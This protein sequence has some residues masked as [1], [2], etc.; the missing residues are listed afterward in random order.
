MKDN[1]SNELC[2]ATSADLLRTE[3]LLIYQSY[4]GS[5]PSSFFK[6]FEKLGK[7]RS[8][9]FPCNVEKHIQPLRVQ[10]G[11][12]TTLESCCAFTDLFN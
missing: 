1:S 10:K 9:T 6:R 7:T 12:N 2:D 8:S 5:L 3:Q 11:I 4:V